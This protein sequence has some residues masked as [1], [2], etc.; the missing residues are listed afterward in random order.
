MR[1]AL[2]WFARGLGAL[3]ALALTAFVALYL[4]HRHPL[5]A[6]TPGPGAEALARRMNAAVNAEA[7]ARTGAIRWTARDGARHLWD[8]RRNFARYEKGGLRVL[9]DLGTRRGRAWRD[10]RPLSGD[11]SRRAL[12]LAWRR[13]VND[14]F[15][16][17]PIP[18][19]FD[20]G[21]RRGLARDDAGRDALLVTYTTG[22]V[23]PGDRYLWIV[24]DTGLPRA[25]RL[26]V[27]VIPIPG[28]EATWEGWIT[29]PTGAR[30][31]TR[32]N[33]VGVTISFTG[34]AAAETLDALEGPADPFAAM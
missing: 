25:W 30:I 14:S 29:L 3:V 22:G 21:V 34:I 33:L 2:R 24:D 10:G 7:W 17:N 1:R 4:A 19:V 16:L 18:K 9:I 28:V 11:A 12:D 27:S 23:T 13:W 20:E 6:A 5:P 15:W 32:H 26:W 31:A 8:R